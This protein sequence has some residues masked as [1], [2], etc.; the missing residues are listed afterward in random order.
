MDNCGQWLFVT[1]SN[2]DL[3]YNDGTLIALSLKRAADG[4]RCGES[5]GVHHQRRLRRAFE[6]HRRQLHLGVHHQRR[7]RRALELHRR[8]RCTVGDCSRV[9]YPNPRTDPAHFCCWD[10]LDRNALNCDERAYIGPASDIGNGAGNVPHRQLR[11]GHGA[12]AA[13]VPDE[14]HGALPRMRRGIGC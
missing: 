1:N 12:A 14:L 2:A 3:R 4:S 5:A 8:A 10:A 11:G 6:L 9:S 13:R 7:L